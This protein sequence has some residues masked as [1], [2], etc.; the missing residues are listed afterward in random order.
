MSIFTPLHLKNMG[1]ITVS[2]RSPRLYFPPAYKKYRLIINFSFVNCYRKIIAPFLLYLMYYM[3]LSF[4]YNFLVLVLVQSIKN[5][6]LL[7]LD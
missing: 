3:C 5:S 1:N 6:S 7:L 2:L 4:F